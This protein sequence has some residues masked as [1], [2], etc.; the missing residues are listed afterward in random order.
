M[1]EIVAER[2]VLRWGGLTGILGGILMIL[3]FVF[4]GVIVGLDPAGLDG[5]V[6]R[7]PDV[8]AARTVENSL[9][10]LVLIMWVPFFLALY[11]ALREASLAP[12]L[13]GS[14]LS[15]LGLVVLAAGALPHVVT[16]RISDLYHGAGA[17]SEGS[18]GTRPLVAGEPGHVRCVARH[19][20]RPPA[21]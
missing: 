5:P 11:R 15:I 10:L 9:Y 2:G 1:K 7:F 19:R 21:D 17:T 16:S 4:V 14:V 13:F 20:A 8:R 18:G 3:V 12:A 6:E